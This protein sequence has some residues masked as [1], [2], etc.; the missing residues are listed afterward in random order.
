MQTIGRCRLR[1]SILYDTP[2]QC[3]NIE[4]IYYIKRYYPSKNVLS[5]L[6][7]YLECFNINESE[8]QLSIYLR[9]RMIKH[10]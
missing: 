3:N 2:V 4:I 10:S 7:V 8:F 5:Q 6:I 1:A 9:K